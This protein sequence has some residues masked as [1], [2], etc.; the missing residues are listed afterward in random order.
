M[1]EAMSSDVLNM[2]FIDL[3]GV[4]TKMKEAMSSDVLLR[5]NFIDLFGVDTKL[6]L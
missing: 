5:T 3:F 6:I 4:D 2:N 1:K